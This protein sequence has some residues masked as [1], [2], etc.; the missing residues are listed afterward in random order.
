MIV[1]KIDY[2]LRILPF[3]GHPLFNELTLSS[4]KVQTA[5]ARSRGCCY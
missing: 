4:R 2:A 3:R 5:T 1:R